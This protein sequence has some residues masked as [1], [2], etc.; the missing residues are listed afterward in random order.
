MHVKAAVMRIKILVSGLLHFQHQV[1]VIHQF[2]LPQANKAVYWVQ[3]LDTRLLC[4]IFPE[5][6]KQS[7]NGIYVSFKII[8]YG[9]MEEVRLVEVT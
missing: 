9:T 5:T 7:P 4:S 8:N 1:N 6:G 3:V 2:I